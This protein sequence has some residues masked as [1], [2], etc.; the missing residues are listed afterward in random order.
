MN[1]TY[2]PNDSKHAKLERSYFYEVVSNNNNN[3]D[4]NNNNNEISV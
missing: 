3:N 4:N 1:S 2:L